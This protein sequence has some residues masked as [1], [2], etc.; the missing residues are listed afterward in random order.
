MD[1][2]NYYLITDLV[3][4]GELFDRICDHGSYNEGIAK[5]LTI[6][7]LQA[8]QFIHDNSIVHRDIKPENLLLMDNSPDAKLKIADFGVA[9]WTSHL[10]SSGYQKCGTPE[11][12]APE[13]YQK[14]ES[15]YGIEV[16]IWAFGCVMFIMLCG[17]HPFQNTADFDDQKHKILAGAVDLDDEPI[18]D[19][20]KSFIQSMLEVNPK[21]RITIAAALK[22]QWLKE[23]ASDS[24]PLVESQAKLKQY[25]ARKRFRKVSFA[26]LAATRSAFRSGMKKH[27][28][29]AAEPEAA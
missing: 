28:T 2:D 18:S 14:N 1:Q 4:G 11:Y 13:M 17:W 23:L 8:L 15:S 5:Q 20:A 3:K 19:E 22:H 27:K 26:V 29:E 21:K 10:K 7:M 24:K 16:D 9:T 12:M 25:Q 6:A